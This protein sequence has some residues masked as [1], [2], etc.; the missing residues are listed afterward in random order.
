MQA[1]ETQEDPDAFSQEAGSR[2]LSDEA[3]CDCHTDVPSPILDANIEAFGR[4][5]MGGKSS[6]STCPTCRKALCPPFAIKLYLVNEVTCP[7]C[8]E[9]VRPIMGLAC[10]H[11]LCVAC[12]EIQFPFPTAGPKKTVSNTEN[13]TY[14][15]PYPYYKDVT[16][17]S[18]G[19]LPQIH[20]E[21]YPHL[22]AGNEALFVSYENFDTVFKNT[23]RR[24]QSPSE[25]NYTTTK[26]RLTK[27]QDAT[28]RWKI[29]PVNNIMSANAIK[30]ITY[31]CDIP[32]DFEFNESFS[33][34]EIELIKKFPKKLLEFAYRSVANSSPEL[35]AKYL[36]TCLYVNLTRK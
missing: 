27:L 16:M 10:G 34:G 30:D 4:L 14:I 23:G 11:S 12:F 5:S 7:V 3:G 31:Y 1:S 33:R 28:M 13:S 26:T 9:D 15:D 22:Y 2:I 20:R 18:D 25:R 21:E 17:W 32:S 6:G 29:D 19:D 36:V 24:T 35:T 8:L